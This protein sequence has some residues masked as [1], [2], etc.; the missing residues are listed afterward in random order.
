MKKRMTYMMVKKRIVA[1]FAVI[2]LIKTEMNCMTKNEHELLDTLKILKIQ[3]STNRMENVVETSGN[4][5]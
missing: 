1:D 4:I 2:S 3:L 5:L